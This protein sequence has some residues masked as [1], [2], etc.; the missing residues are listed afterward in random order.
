[1]AA[2]KRKTLP[3][4]F[5]GL[6]KSGDIEA[7][8]TQFA[9]CEPNAVTSK[10][11]SNVF[12]LTPLPREFAFWAREQGA[13]VNFLD[14]Y[15]RT[16]LFN[17]SSFYNGDAA[18]LI[19][20]GAD[21]NAAGRN[22]GTTPLHLAATYGR[23][24]ALKALLAAGARVDARQC[25]VLGHRYTP[26]EMAAVQHRVPFALL[27]GVCGLLL[28]AGAEMTDTAREGICRASEEFQRNKRGMTDPEWIRS[29]TEGLEQL[30]RMF[31]VQPAAEVPFHDGV[32]PI[33]I[34]EAGFAAQ[35]NKLW[36]YLIPPVGRAQT[37]QGEAVRIAG[38]VR[39]ELLRN[40]GAN[41][42]G[43]YR[44]MLAIFPEYLRLG[45][46]LSGQDQADAARIAKLLMSAPVDDTLTK[47]LC[48]YA[49]RWVL[50]NPD[51]LPPL[52]ADYKR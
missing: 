6:L 48:E 25:G 52:K 9:R 38:R 2:K 37:A 8:K 32:S 4:E 24:K 31:D 11:G 33:I 12:S 47:A 34:T 40:G 26:L 13:D 28:E 41:W 18:L 7:L 15:G 17:Q 10:Y 50:Q 49:V 27:A 23:V 1:M 39:D 44:K 42:D 29:Q 45:R 20:L 3:K 21:V 51:V 46:P 16:P 43:E 30:Y 19:E 14:Y 36:D 22:D 5:E 35:Y